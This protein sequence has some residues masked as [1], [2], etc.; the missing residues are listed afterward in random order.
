[1]KGNVLRVKARS[2]E[3]ARKLAVANVPKGLPIVFEEILSDGEPHTVTR[4]ADTLEIKF[5]RINSCIGVFMLFCIK[6]IGN[7][8]VQGF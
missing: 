7:N 2:L 3:A 1:M 5:S 4:T 6:S 8:P